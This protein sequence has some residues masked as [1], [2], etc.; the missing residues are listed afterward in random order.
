LSRDQLDVLH[1][2][3]IP[4]STRWSPVV[5]LPWSA[6]SWKCPNSIWSGCG[7]P[8]RN[9]CLRCTWPTIRSGRK[10]SKTCAVGPTAALASIS[11]CSWR[12][13]D[14][15]GIGRLAQYMTVSTTRA[16][17]DMP[18]IDPFFGALP[19]V[20]SKGAFEQS[21]TVAGSADGDGSGQAPSKQRF[22]QQS[23]DTQHFRG[24]PAGIV[25]DRRRFGR[26]VSGLRPSSRLTERFFRSLYRRRSGI[27][28]LWRSASAHLKGKQRRGSGSVLADLGLGRKSLKASAFGLHLRCCLAYRFAIPM[29]KERW[30]NHGR[31][32][33]SMVVR[34]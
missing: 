31:H 10:S 16:A 5:R 23:P 2:S 12:R 15:P 27:G 6:T 9:P 7:Q 34:R 1:D 32:T 8:G 19:A 3:D 26:R 30:F 25:P 20:P 21:G 17:C 24:R 18:K 29:L 4:T 11:R 13:P 22:L 14:R 28:P 33:G